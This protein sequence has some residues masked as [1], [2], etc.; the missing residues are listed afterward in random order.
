VLARHKSLVK[1]PV[2]RKYLSGYDILECRHVCY[3]E[4]C[5]RIVAIEYNDV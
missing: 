1:R 3:T 2:K 4:A 5:N